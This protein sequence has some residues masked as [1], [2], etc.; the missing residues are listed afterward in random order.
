[1][2]W[3]NY[4]GNDYYIQAIK[5]T[6][7]FVAIKTAKNVLKILLNFSSEAC[8]TSLSNRNETS[9]VGICTPGLECQRTGGVGEGRLAD[10]QRLKLYSGLLTQLFKN[11]WVGETVRSGCSADNTCSFMT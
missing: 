3:L 11:V 5:V 10:S 4:I 6:I 7:Y 1:M 8:H 2:L 9:N